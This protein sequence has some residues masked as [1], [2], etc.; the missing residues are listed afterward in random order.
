MSALAEIAEGIVEENVEREER[1]AVP[2]QVPC[3]EPH[4]RG[5]IFPHEVEMVPAHAG[6]CPGCRA[7]V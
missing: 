1:E 4:G 2:G 5:G 6:P 7:A 3:T